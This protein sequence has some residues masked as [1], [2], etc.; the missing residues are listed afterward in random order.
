MYKES[1][2]NI[3]SGS[4]CMIR[5]VDLDN[6]NNNYSKVNLGVT[7]ELLWIMAYWHPEFSR[8]QLICDNCLK[9]IDLYWLKKLISLIKTISLRIYVYED[10]F[11]SFITHNNYV[12]IY[13]SEI[14]ILLYICTRTRARIFRNRS[15][16]K[17]I[18]NNSLFHIC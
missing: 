7:L 15:N 12:C 1:L 2:G 10:F 13:S 16:N 6:S 18:I 4:F 5:T 3:K 11:V 8:Y 9:T 14:N 17:M